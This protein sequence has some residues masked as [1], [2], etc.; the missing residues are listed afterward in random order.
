M[1]RIEAAA[2]D[3]VITQSRKQRAH[4]NIR[5]LGNDV[6]HDDWREV[7]QEEYADAHRYAQRIL[8]DLYDD[9]QTVEDV[10]KAKRR[11]FATLLTQ[12]KPAH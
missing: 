11:T 8:E 6:L 3:G 7:S 1:H 4:E 9:R 2:D 10:L 5:V 12:A